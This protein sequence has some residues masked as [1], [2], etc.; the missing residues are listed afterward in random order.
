MIFAFVPKWYHCLRM[1]GMR[2]INHGSCGLI[3]GVLVD[4]DF[5]QDLCRYRV[6]FSIIAPI[7][8]L[9]KRTCVSLGL[10]NSV[11]LIIR[12]VYIDLDGFLDSIRPP[13]VMKLNLVDLIIK[14]GL[15]TALVGGECDV[16]VVNYNA[17]AF[18]VACVASAFAA[19]ASRVIVVDNASHDGSLDTLR[20]SHRAGNSLHIEC[21]SANLG[22]SA[23]C[24]IGARISVAPRVFFLNP[25]SVLAVDALHCLVQALEDSPHEIGR[26]SCRERVS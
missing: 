23:A 21:N 22:F 25:D 7:R 19:G 2:V 16:V 24:N 4:A 20:R 9:R 12:A 6:Y 26:A 8:L 5:T 13:R 14:D 18:L 1:L 11:F 10:S 3:A 15:T 17:G